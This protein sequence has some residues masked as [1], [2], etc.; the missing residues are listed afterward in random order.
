ML[1]SFDIYPA[2]KS[3]NHPAPLHNTTNTLAATQFCQHH[4]SRYGDG[5]VGGVCIVSGLEFSLAIWSYLVIAP[6]LTHQVIYV[7]GSV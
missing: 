1:L 5:E 2:V 4:A 6:V 7:E 3:L